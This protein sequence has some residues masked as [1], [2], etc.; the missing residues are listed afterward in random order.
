VEPEVVD[1]PE[2]GEPEVVDGVPAAPA[3]AAAS[4]WG[5]TMLVV[6]AALVEV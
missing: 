1:E 6:A 5:A 4:V 2:V 3:A